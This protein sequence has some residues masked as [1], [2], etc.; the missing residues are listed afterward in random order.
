MMKR[1]IAIFL[2][3][4][5]LQPFFYTT[6]MAL[7]AEQQEYQ[8]KIDEATEK[9]DQI[10]AKKDDVLGEISDLEDSIYQKEEEIEGLNVQIKKLE[11]N[12]KR[13]KE[14][15]VKLEEEYKKNEKELEDKLVTI[16][17]K[18]QITFLDVLLSSESLTDFI[19]GMYMVQTLTAADNELLDS[20]EKESTEVE[21]AKKEL[22]EDKTELAV[23]KKEVENKKASLQVSKAEK[24]E[25]VENL[26]D[27]EKSLQSDIEEYKAELERIDEEIKK[28]EEEAEN[29]YNGS[30]N[31]V[32]GWP[33]SSNSYGYNIITSDYGERESPAAGASTFHRGI[34][35]GVDI[36]TPVF[37]SADGYVLSVM[38]TGARGLFVLIKH[39]EDLYTR[40]QHLDSSNVY[41]GQ[42]V[43]RGD[44]IA[45]SGNSGIGSGPHLHFEVLYAPYWTCEMNPL[46]CGLVDIPSNLIY[47]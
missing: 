27:E 35:L 13:K 28:Q 19:S 32:L 30:F 25:M 29:I 4:V 39:A 41:E 33:I 16:Y 38:E 2:M 10:E 22:E 1:I 14:E 21:K 8:D 26:S 34:D 12:I 46:T 43:K 3:L 7:T 24:E 40:Y 23:T 37:S 47:Y 44:L 9:K 31:G 20:L 18:G 11:N 45:H 36:G 6:A 17:E 42:Y 5:L 15:L